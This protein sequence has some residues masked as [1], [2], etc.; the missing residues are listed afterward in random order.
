MIAALFFLVYLLTPTSFY[1]YD[2]LTAALSLEFGQ[3]PQN[4]FNPFHLLAPIPGF[5]VYKLAGITGFPVRVLYIMQFMN[6]ALGAIAVALFYRALIRR[7]DRWTAWTGAIFFGCSHAFWYETTD[8]GL[9]AIAGLTVCWLLLVL[10][11]E[12]VSPLWL[13][14]VHGVAIACH[15][16]MLLVL[17]ACLLLLKGKRI[18]RYGLGLFLTAGLSYAV[19]LAMYWQLEIHRSFGDILAWLIGP[20][21]ASPA[22][23]ITN[24][25]SWS[26]DFFSNAREL[27]SAWSDALL[28]PLPF[29][30]LEILKQLVLAGAL[31]WFIVSG[32]KKKRYWPFLAWI[33]CLNIFQFFYAAGI[34]RFQILFLPVVIFL[35]LDSATLSERPAKVRWGVLGMA[36]MVAFSN[37][38]LTIRPLMLPANNPSFVRAQWVHQNLTPQDF[39]FFSGRF[40]DSMINVYKAYF[41]PNVPARS[42]EGYLYANPDGNLA[43][44]MMTMNAQ[45]QAGGR[46]FVDASLFDAT[47]QN[48]FEEA[49]RLQ[50]RT[51]Q[52]W[53][54]AFQQLERFRDDT[55]Y[56]IVRVK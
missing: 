29:A 34:L 28:S 38:A 53:F 20:P 48:Q 2:S 14:V 22:Q 4:L 12:T 15:G 44:L 54:G 13:G 30:P 26:V 16:M 19:A 6:A 8:A 37:F 11:D 50:K 5:L 21:A 51:L 40:G 52:S 3:F 17:P 10:Q 46:V 7:F 27:W 32:V 9:Y 33:L 56:E 45:A 49:H 1:S 18:L 25:P 35:M 43:P 24:N 55:G 36:F 23:S 31:L 41:A 42:L 39:L 47:V